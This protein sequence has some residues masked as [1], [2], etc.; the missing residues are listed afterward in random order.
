[1]Y[2]KELKISPPF[3]NASGILSFV[4]VFEYLEKLGVNV[5]AWVTKSIGQKERNGNENPVIHQD[6]DILM[7]SV[8]LSSPNLDDFE[9][10][11]KEYKG[12]T[13]LIISHYGEKPDD[14][15]RSVARFD[16]YCIAHEINLS[17]PNFIP[18]EKSVLEKVNPQEILKAVREK[19]NKPIIAKLSPAQDY[20]E[21]TERILDYVDYICCGNTIRGL[22]IEPISGFS[23]LSGRFGGISGEVLRPITMKMVYEI[24]KEFGDKIGIIA[25]GGI[26]KPEH[27][28]SYARAGAS[29]FQI[30]TA[31][32]KPSVEI[33]NFF[34]TLGDGIET[35]LKKI[36]VNSIE[37]IVGVNYVD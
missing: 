11:L 19:T 33:V 9:K 4:S 27:I 36:G 34:N 7:N 10:E 12:K 26:S 31:L 1:M 8:G 15:A 2:Y 16:K 6:G 18:G 21:I 17:C 5:G 29:L 3:M 30:G 24:Y 25:C 13:P 22:D 20:L 35:L 23:Y 32:A 14:Y 37:D 28:I